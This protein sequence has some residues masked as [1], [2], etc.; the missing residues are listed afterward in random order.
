MSL[1]KKIISE[2][3]EQKIIE[4]I[5]QQFVSMQKI[6]DNNNDDLSLETIDDKLMYNDYY[7]NQ[8]ID[9]IK[10]NEKLND[11]LMN[12]VFEKEAENIRKSR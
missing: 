4:N 1:H 3:D 2:I 11:P 5:I 12:L 9:Y 8:G 6:D 7:I 10:R